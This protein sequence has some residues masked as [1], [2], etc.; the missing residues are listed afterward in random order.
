ML[1]L[2]CARQ[3]WTFEVIVCLDV[4]AFRR[5][6]EY[7]AAMRGGQVKVADR[8]YASSKTFSA[9]RHKRAELPLSVRA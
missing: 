9:C 3:G 8:F 5:Q 1:E 4:F 7:K 6:L 2:Y